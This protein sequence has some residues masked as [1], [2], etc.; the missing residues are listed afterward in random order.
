MP[1]AV[2]QKIR[3]WGILLICLISTRRRVESALPLQVAGDRPARR[4]GCT[5]IVAADAMEFDLADDGKSH[6]EIKLDRVMVLGADVKPRDQAF[7]AMVSREMPDEVCS[8]TL[9]A[10]RRMRADA[11]NF[12][13]AV[14]CDTFAAHC[15]Q[16]PFGSHTIVKA[17]FARSA[18]EEARERDVGECDH[19]VRVFAGEWDDTGDWLGRRDLAGQ[20]HLETLEIFCAREFR[21]G[22]VTFSYEPDVL[23]GREERMKRL[24]GALARRR[25][26]REW[27]DIGWIAAGLPAGDGKVTMPGLEGMPHRICEEIL[28][29]VRHSLKTYSWFAVTSRRVQRR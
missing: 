21:H 20:D 29:E 13:V 8:V 7:A 19:L 17:H 15:D 16:V 11:A 24:Q 23:S 5:S 22:G 12:R 4:V 1:A 10:M 9:A 3:L 14:E 28:W 6:P 26:W 25:D 2:A 27:R 18:A